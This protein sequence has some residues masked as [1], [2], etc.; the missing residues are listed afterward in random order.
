M[1]S[2]TWTST[3][4][5]PVLRQMLRGQGSSPHLAERLEQF[6]RPQS[7][8][9]DRSRASLLPGRDEVVRMLELKPG[10][11]V[12]DLGAGTGANLEH[13]G[14]ALPALAS[15]TLV[16]LCSSLAGLARARAARHPNVTLVEADMTRWR[17]AQP[18]DV[19]LMSYSLT[20]VP[21][22]FAAI[23]AALDMLRP[24]GRL[25]VVDFYVSRRVPEAGLRAHGLLTRTFWPAWFGHDGVHPSPDHLPYLRYRLETLALHERLHRPVRGVAVPWYIHVGRKR[26]GVA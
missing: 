5:Y 22:W 15:V 18:A 11:H 10:E 26:G 9:Y 4:S 17:P 3:L 19:V 8:D 23:D 21:D 2:R 7:R 1:G 25:G 24:G 12:I 20:M 16:D 6:Y 14:E 13:M